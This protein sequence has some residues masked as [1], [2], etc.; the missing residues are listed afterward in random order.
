MHVPP[1]ARFDDQHHDQFTA[2][3]YLRLG[4]LLSPGELAAL[5]Q[6][7]DDIMLARV[8]YDNMRFQINPKTPGTPL[9][10]TLGNQKQTLNY[11]RIDDLEQDP[12][13]L[14]YMQHALIRQITRR[15]IG[16][17]VSVFRAM[18]MNKPAKSGTILP[19][20]QDIGA[21]WRIDTNPII[22]IWTG[23][24]AATVARGCMQIVPGSNNLGILNERHYTSEKDRAKYARPEAVIDLE[25]EAGEAVLLHNFLLHRSGVNTTSAPRRAFSATYMDARTRSLRT[26]QTFPIL[27]G[28]GA[29]D[30]ATVAGKAADQVQVFHG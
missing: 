8:R 5:Q 26:G 2:Q 18:F 9:S 22:T 6:R 30:P 29:L 21:G 7:I 11:R 19:W 13:F 27:F 20:H 17:N 4:H 14:A 12:L 10:R 15:Y 3:G 28:R 1:L 25:T 16:K 24:D 23:L